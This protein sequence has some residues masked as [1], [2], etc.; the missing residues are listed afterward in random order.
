LTTLETDIEHLLQSHIT[1]FRD[2]HDLSEPIFDSSLSHILTSCLIHLESTKL[3]PPSLSAQPA[4]ATLDFQESVKRTIP[5][6]HTFKGF[7]CLFGDGCVD[8]TK[9]WKGL[10]RVKHVLDIL[11]TRGDTVRFGVRVVVV[12]YAEDVAAVWVMV[13]VRFKALSL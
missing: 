11:K 10:V 8:A 5:L 9:I 2:D 4:P 12:G 1:H 3:F 13:A 6:G 7:P